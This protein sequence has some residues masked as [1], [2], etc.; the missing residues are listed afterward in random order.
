MGITT[1]GLGLVEY[2]GET[3]GPEPL[4]SRVQ[5]FVFSSQFGGW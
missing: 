4:K 1:Y 3:R 5:G 2:L